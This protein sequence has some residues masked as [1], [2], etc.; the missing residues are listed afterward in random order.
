MVAWTLS[1]KESL[2]GLASKSILQSYRRRKRAWLTAVQLILRLVL[3]VAGLGTI[4]WG[5]YELAFWAGLFATGV[6]LLLLD[7]WRSTVVAR[8]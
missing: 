1:G 7:V 4:C 5:F 2:L 8:R 6:S 3:V